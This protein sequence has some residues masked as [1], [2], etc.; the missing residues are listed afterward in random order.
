MKTFYSCTYIV[1]P[2][3]RSHATNVAEN[4]AY[5][6]EYATFWGKKQTIPIILVEENEIILE[7]FTKT[8]FE[9]VGGSGLQLPQSTLTYL[10][11]SSSSAH[12]RRLLPTEALKILEPCMKNYEKY[13]NAIN[14]YFDC[15]R[16]EFQ[17]NQEEE[18]QAKRKEL[19]A[20]EIL[21]NLWRKH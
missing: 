1:H 10:G 16:D 19:N 11:R 5:L 18:L 7:F 12:Y 8:K 20:E 13:A 9:R 17:R 4:A 14:K 21:S 3:H 2:Y 15:F 6:L